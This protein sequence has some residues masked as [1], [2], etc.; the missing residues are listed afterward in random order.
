[1]RAFIYKCCQHPHN[2]DQRNEDRPERVLS[3]RNASA[4]NSTYDV[5]SLHD[6]KRDN[7]TPYFKVAVS[8][9]ESDNEFNDCDDQRRQRAVNAT[10]S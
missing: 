10:V 1:M 9:C 6:G 2:E 7:D 4:R 5:T 3:L 8:D